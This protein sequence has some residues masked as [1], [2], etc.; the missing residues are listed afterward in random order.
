MIYPI[1]KAVKDR[2]TAK[3]TEN[4]IKGIEWYNVQYEGSIT[5][6]PRIFIEF[7]DKIPFNPQ[8]KEITRGEPVLRIHLVTKTLSDTKGA[9]NDSS[10]E[11]HDA[12]AD[13]ILGWLRG[14]LPVDSENNELCRK[15][16]L[17][18]WQHWHKYKGYMITFIDFT[19]K[20]DVG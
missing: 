15:L 14:F 5:T 11:D 1:F 20:I 4:T 9:V 2:I 6:T 18:G 12:L 16:R 17:N 7:P 8:S 3:D 10:A 19:L 13:T